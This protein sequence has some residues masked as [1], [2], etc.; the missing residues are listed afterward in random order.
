[1]WTVAHE[2][3]T[4]STH[5][6]HTL[7]CSLLVGQGVDASSNPAAAPAPIDY[8]ALTTY[9]NRM[10][11]PQAPWYRLH[12]LTVLLAIL[13]AIGLLVQQ[14]IIGPYYWRGWPL[15]E[16]LLAGAA[17]LG[18]VTVV[19]EWWSRRKKRKFRLQLSTVLI[20]LCVANGFVLLNFLPSL[21]DKG[22]HGEVS[23]G[24]PFAIGMQSEDSTII[25]W[26]LHDLWMNFL[27]GLLALALLGWLLELR[28]PRK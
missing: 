8:R 21:H 17:I 10:E 9:V 3:G 19:S 28:A 7:T 26:S 20:L 18:T 2:F 4:P 11:Q 1:M 6:A 14:I 5:V 23:Y 16:N 25:Y 12:R 24:F 22:V 27:S 13:C 15:V